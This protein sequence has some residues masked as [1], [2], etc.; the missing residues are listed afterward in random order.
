[1]P[2]L[3]AVLIVHNEERHLPDCL[4]SLEGLADEIV[5]L[6]DGSK[7]RT[8]EIARA[9][10]ARVEHR[11]FDD[12]G[13]QFQAALDLAAGDWVFPIDADER[14]SPELAASMRAVVDAPDSLE[15]YWVR[16]EI[17]YMG[18]RMKH[19][20]LGDDWVLRLAKRG[21]VRYNQVVV[22]PH[23]VL[24]GRSARLAGVMDHV[25]YRKLSEHV[26]KIDGYTETM[27]LARRERGQRFS[28]WQVLRIPW[29]LFYRLFIRGGVLDGKP[30]V[31]WAGMSAFYSFLKSAKMWSAGDP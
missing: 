21:L 24:D 5:V 23:L 29:E 28:S 25:Q 19:G 13:H 18:A 6:D 17:I 2:R 10:G 31:I 30:G 3:S 20:G 11:P 26:A 12:F 14:V 22:H 16:R 27:A 8:V 4:R 1:M 7:D 15:G 9:A